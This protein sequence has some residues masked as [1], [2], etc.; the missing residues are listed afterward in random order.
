MTRRCLHEISPGCKPAVALAE[1]GIQPL[2]GLS[3]QAPNSALRV[4]HSQKSLYP[5]SFGLFHMTCYHEPLDNTNDFGYT[6]EYERQTVV[7]TN[8]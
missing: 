8:L 5:S 2:A 7:S 4:K 3:V 6:E 1:V